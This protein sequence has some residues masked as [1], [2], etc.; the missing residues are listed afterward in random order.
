MPES[1]EETNTEGETQIR[2]ICLRSN[3]LVHMPG[4]IAALQND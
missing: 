2:E 3:D 1:E 4:Y